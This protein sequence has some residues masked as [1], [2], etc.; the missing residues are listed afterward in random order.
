[1]ASGE[2]RV[3]SSQWLENSGQ[4]P[5]NLWGREI[6]LHAS[7][8]ALHASRSTPHAPR[9]HASRPTHRCLTAHAVE[10]AL[11]LGP[12]L[13]VVW[14]FLDSAGS[15]LP[16][17]TSFVLGPHGEDTELVYSAICVPAVQVEPASWDRNHPRFLDGW[18][19]FE[20]LYFLLPDACSVPVKRGSDG[21]L[22]RS[23]EVVLYASGL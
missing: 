13:A 3:N 8:P 2:W 23:T 1:V 15:W 19:N 5:V 4:W 16:W 12:G 11:L 17:S 6:T 20:N 21:G 9:P 10:F 7:R 22:R 18:R 14:S